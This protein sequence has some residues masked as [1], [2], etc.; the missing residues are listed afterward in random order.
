MKQPSAANDYYRHEPTLILVLLLNSVLKFQI[1]N[2]QLHPDY[3]AT[4]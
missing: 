4:F 2:L 1:S 3:A